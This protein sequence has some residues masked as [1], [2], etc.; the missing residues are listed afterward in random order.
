MDQFLK[1]LSFGEKSRLSE[2][3]KHARAELPE[4]LKIPAEKVAAM[5]D[6][7]AGVR[8]YVHKRLARDQLMAAALVLPPREAWPLLKQLRTETKAMREKTG[9]KGA[10]FIDPTAM[11]ITAWSQ[12]RKIQSLRVIEAVRHHL[13]THDG[14]LPKTLDEIQDLSIPLDPLT[15]QPFQWTVDGQTAV[16]KAPPLPADVIEPGLAAAAADAS[17]LEYRLRVK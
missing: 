7:E 11:F 10:D 17:V 3:N 9:A 15:D 13:A 6:D 5:S 1:S 14:K 16:L 12:R 2:L 8:W 4:L